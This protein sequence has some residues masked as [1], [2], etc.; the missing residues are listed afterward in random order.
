M[1]SVLNLLFQTLESW[2][3]SNQ[4]E[5]YRLIRPTILR[6]FVSTS[7][8][9]IFSF[10]P[11]QPNSVGSPVTQSVNTKRYSICSTCPRMGLRLSVRNVG[12]AQEASES[13]CYTSHCITTAKKSCCRIPR[14]AK[15]P[16]QAYAPY[17]LVNESIVQLSYESFICSN[18]KSWLSIPSW[19]EGVWPSTDAW[20]EPFGQCAPLHWKTMAG[21]QIA[22][23]FRAIVDGFHGDQDFLHK[24]FEFKRALD[25]K[26]TFH[27][28]T[29]FLPSCLFLRKLA[30]HAQEVLPMV[31]GAGSTC[32]ETSAL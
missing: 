13:F 17:P 23:P 3:I 24:L 11:W 22:G 27:E 5:R 1:L 25:A 20:G 21:E 19:G 32:V 4:V 8:S 31:W 2:V 7:C 30:Q 6:T 14:R 16:N 15:R 29:I 26:N 12:P 9:F 10:K 28:S 18:N